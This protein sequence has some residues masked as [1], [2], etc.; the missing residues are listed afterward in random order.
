MYLNILFN[1]DNGDEHRMD[2]PAR[3]EVCR[4]CGGKGTELCGAMKGAAY[5]PE[6]LLHDADFAESMAA[7]VYDVTCGRCCGKRVELVPA[8]E[9]CGERQKAAV[10]AWEDRTRRD[11]REAW[12]D[13]QTFWAECGTPINERY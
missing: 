12:E 11:D 13:Q 2:V 9:E 4:A 7:G 3:Y 6:D 8:I 1:D 10:V 5:S